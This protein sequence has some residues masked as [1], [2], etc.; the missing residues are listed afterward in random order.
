MKDNS[1]SRVESAK[2][3]VKAIVPVLFTLCISVICLYVVEMFSWQDD[4]YLVVILGY[5]LISASIFLSFVF[6]YKKQEINV[7]GLIYDKL[8]FRA[9]GSLFPDEVL[10]KDSK[11]YSF[12]L[13]KNKM[14]FSLF[15]LLA[16]ALLFIFFKM[17]ISLNNYLNVRSDIAEIKE[18]SV[19]FVPGSNDGGS[20]DYLIGFG[21]EDL[22]LGNLVEKSWLEEL[23]RNIEIEVDTST[24]FVRTYEIAKNENL[25]SLFFR[26]KGVFVITGSLNNSDANIVVEFYSYKNKDIISPMIPVLDFVYENGYYNEGKEKDIYLRFKELAQGKQAYQLRQY[27]PNQVS[28]EYALAKGVQ[29]ELVFFIAKSIG[30]DLLSQV[31]NNSLLDPEVA[32]ENDALI[33]NAL[34][35]L[36]LAEKNIPEEFNLWSNKPGLK[37]KEDVAELYD[38]LHRIYILKAA[39]YLGKLVDLESDNRFDVITEV[40]LSLK[41]AESYLVRASRIDKS[42]SSRNVD[43]QDFLLSDGYRH[44]VVDKYLRE[45]SFYYIE[46]IFNYAD[47]TFT[48]D[49]SILRQDTLSKMNNVYARKLCGEGYGML[50]NLK[51][52]AREESSKNEIY[53]KKM[54]KVAV[55]NK[56]NY[57]SDTKEMRLVRMMND[58]FE[59]NILSEVSSGMRDVVDNQCE[60][61]SLVRRYSR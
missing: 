53:L 26:S 55:Q 6:F 17:T 2:G 54:N 29:G 1:L 47:S 31:D 27:Y 35:A 32:T 11:R 8:L 14:R 52:I 21:S 44:L 38:S 19:S 60:V 40:D 9:F 22:F 59:R 41:V 45:Y 49:Y 13:G 57:D 25:D 24:N 33:S 18:R 42:Y 39:S 46:S 5:L 30:E 4:N 7:K 10:R 43:L 3:S 23:K 37:S 58:S 20:D 51:R 12:L 36:Q 16:S 56:R 34:K 28:R 48:R 15:I 50:R 61:V